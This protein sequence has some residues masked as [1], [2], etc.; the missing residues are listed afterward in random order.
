MPH[1]CAVQKQMNRSRCRLRADSHGPK[2]PCIGWLSRSPIGRGNLAVVR[3]S[4]KHWESLLRYMQQKGSLN[5]NNGLTARLLQ[6]TAMLST[7]RCHVT[8]ITLPP[9]KN[10]PAMRPFVKN[11]LTTCS[12]CSTGCHVCRCYCRSRHLHNGHLHWLPLPPTV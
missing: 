3:A 1:G 10:P 8:L 9:V 12:A 4:E 11:S 2:E 6:P 5:P 7:G